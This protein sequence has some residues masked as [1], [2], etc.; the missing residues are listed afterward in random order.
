MRRNLDAARDLTTRLASPTCTCTPAAPLDSLLPG[1]RL[2][3][4]CSLELC[5]LGLCFLGLCPG[6]LCSL[7][8]CFLASCAVGS[9]SHLPLPPPPPVLLLLAEATPSAD[10]AI[11][12]GE[13]EGEGCSIG[14]GVRAVSSCYRPMREREE[15]SVGPI[16]AME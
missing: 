11:W 2:L 7:G 16:P 10:W 14:P 4:P 13:G 1:Y 12:A 6:E 9:M 3:R 5:S 15:G 8:L